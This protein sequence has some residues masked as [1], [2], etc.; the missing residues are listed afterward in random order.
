MAGPPPYTAHP[1]MPAREGAS[2]PSR[3]QANQSGFNVNFQAGFEQH[4]LLQAAPPSQSFTSTFSN[5]TFVNT[6]LNFGTAGHQVIPGPGAPH[7]PSQVARDG[8]NSSGRDQWHNSN[9]DQ[10]EEEMGR[11]ADGFNPEH[12]R[13]QDHMGSLKLLYSC[14]AVPAVS[15]F[16]SNK[17]RY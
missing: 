9:F 3:R 5:S 13:R 16:P 17:S 12:G 14:R 4:P 10:V 15:D 2:I 7:P 8:P 11:V 1:A 6:Q